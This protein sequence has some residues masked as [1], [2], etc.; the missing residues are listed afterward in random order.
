MGTS[1]RHM[2]D[3][4]HEIGAIDARVIEAVGLAKSRWQVA[5]AANIRAVTFAAGLAEPSWPVSAS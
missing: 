4:L 5:A 1:A 2:M 3:E